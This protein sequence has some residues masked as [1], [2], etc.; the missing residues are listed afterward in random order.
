MQFVSDG[1]GD[2]VL[3]Q[4]ADASEARLA[5]AFFNPD[6]RMLGALAALPK[7]TLVISE[8]FTVNNPYKL[9][10]LASA[11]LRS[12]PPDAAGGKLHAK[13]LIV[14]RRDGT[15]WVLLG[16]ANLTRSGMFANQEAC[17]TMNSGNSADARQVREIMEWFDALVSTAQAPDL[18]LAKLVFDARSRYRLMPRLQGKESEAEGYWA[19][20]TTSGSTGKSH[21]QSFLAESVIAVGW[22]ELQVDPSKVS[23]AQLRSAITATYPEEAAAIAATTIRRFVQLREGDIVLL[24]RG[25]APVQERDVHIHGVARVTGPFRDDQHSTWDWHFKHD[26]VIQVIDMDVPKETVARALGKQSLMKTIHVLDKV[27]F[28][29]LAAELKKAGVTIEV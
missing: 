18:E 10:K 15:L 8:E 14:K 21:W 22:R 29:R 16:S 19:L 24:C 13:V 11:T 23:D 25:Y 7:L 26:A 5:V 9:E 6:D 20:K 2:L 27:G 12:V 28:E 4:L 3:A 17:V 1:I